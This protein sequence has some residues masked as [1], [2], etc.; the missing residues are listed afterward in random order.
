M[1]ERI[2]VLA[3][4]S[5]LPWPLDSGGHLRT[6]HIQK[7][8]AR[9]FDVRLL[10]PVMG[11][12]SADIAALSAHG[13]AVMPVPVAPR[14]PIGE[15]IRLL[16]AGM[17]T[18][19]YVMYR[20]HARPE[21][22]DAWRRE[23]AGFRPHTVWLDHLDGFLFASEAADAGCRTILD[24]HN[25]YSLILERMATE[26][27]NRVKKVF[28]RGEARRLAK[29]EA[30][31]CA[32]VDVV[33]A[34]SDAEAEY[35]RRLGGRRVVVAPNGVDV[36]AFADLPTGRQ[37]TPPVVLFLGTLSWGPNVAAAV[38][39]ARDIFPQVRYRLPDA[40]LLLVGRNP[41]AEVS[42]LHGR[43]G[44]TVARNVPNV[45][46][47]LERAS[48][49]AV[50]LDSGGGTRLKILEAFAAGLPVVSTAVGAEGIDATAGAA[51]VIAERP[52]MADALVNLLS[53]RSRSDHLAAVARRLATSI[54]DWSV[55][56]SR[57]VACVNGSLT[58]SPS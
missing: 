1:N 37:T 24:L 50:P 45:R 54:Y 26:S 51:F 14:T 39:L 31:A 23:L 49:L 18:E 52:G 44:V 22:Y 58:R 32:A 16:R 17:D 13:I 53:D 57:C 36:A 33:V 7:G 34:V 48:V 55:I 56:T 40:E 10:V 12:R 19:P 29:V 6:F 47:Y 41:S 8:L 5:E 3:V 9:E 43:P 28:L 21:V 30:K 15:A 25:V 27:G 2:R 20:R 11:D 38:S 4:T 46:P 42:A 35:Y